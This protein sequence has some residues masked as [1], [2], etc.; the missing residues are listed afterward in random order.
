MLDPRFRVVFFPSRRDPGNNAIATAG[1]KLSLHQPICKEHPVAQRESKDGVLQAER[2][3]KSAVQ[4]GS[5]QILRQ[6]IADWKD[7]AGPKAPVKL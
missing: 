6:A 4:N 7:Q 5:A 2:A 3:L 1:A